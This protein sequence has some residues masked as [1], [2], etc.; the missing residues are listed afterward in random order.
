MQ[1]NSH[2]RI[3]QMAEIG[4]ER[5]APSLEEYQ[6][7]SCFLTAPRQVWPSLYDV[8][9]IS[10]GTPAAQRGHSEGVHKLFGI[11]SRSSRAT[12]CSAANSAMSSPSA[13]SAPIPTTLAPRA[14][15]SEKD[16]RTA[17]PALT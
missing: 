7:S 6:Q 3:P 2:D 5:A 15:K 1:W 12:R 13:R 8:P 16:P 4:D 17:D 11:R 10:S 9:T 14:C